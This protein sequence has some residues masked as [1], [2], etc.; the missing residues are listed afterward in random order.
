MTEEKTWWVILLGGIVT[1]AFGAI[2]LAWPAMTLTFLITIFGSLAIVLGAFGVIRSLF[3]IKEDKSWWILLIEGILGIIIGIVVFVW[4]IGTIAFLVYFIAAWLVIT[5]ISGI[6]LGS[7]GKSA[8]TIVI[9]ILAL[10][11]GIF[12]LFQPP[13]YAVELLLSLIGI[14]AVIR[15]IAL[16]INSIVVA[17][18]GKKARQA[19]A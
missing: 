1:L 17:V 14:I 3:L 15:G 18:A 4:P 2:I 11:F 7:M 19:K 10:I 12:V 16:I 5:G 8:I 6:V 13:N 9:G